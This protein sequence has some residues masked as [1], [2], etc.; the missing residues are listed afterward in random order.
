MDISDSGTWE[1]PVQLCSI[2]RPII[3]SKALKQT[4]A[5]L[6]SSGTPFLVVFFVILLNFGRHFLVK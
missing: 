3:L 2:I 1:K 4:R 5:G 6:R